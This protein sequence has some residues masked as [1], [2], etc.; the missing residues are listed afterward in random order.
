[1]DNQQRST[2]SI[3]ECS[4]TKQAVLSLDILKLLFYNLIN[5]SNNR[6][7]GL[8][9]GQKDLIAV[10]FA[11]GMTSPMMDLECVDPVIKRTMQK[12]TGNENREEKR[13]G[14]K[15]MEVLQ[16][17][18]RNYLSIEMESMLST[19]VPTR[20]NAL[21]VEAQKNSKF[22]IG[23]DM[24]RMFQKECAIMT[25]RTLFFYAPFVMEEFTVKL[26]GGPDNMKNALSVERLI[27]P[28]NLM[29]DVDDAKQESGI[30]SMERARF[31]RDSKDI[32]HPSMKVL[33]SGVDEVWATDLPNQLEREEIFRIHL[34]KRGRDPKKF[35]VLLL[36]QNTDNFTGAE[37]E[38]N[39]EDGM[40][41]SFDLDVEVDNS[42][43]LQAIKATVPQASRDVEE[44]SAV[45]EWVKTRA[46]LVS[47]ADEKE[48]SNKADN[49][50][51]QIVKKKGA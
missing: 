37:I 49:K 27:D 21:N 39:I 25:Q 40:F 38:S 13:N 9:C 12:E 24:V 3:G 10:L 47:G 30:G 16:N 34:Q 28:T 42:H 26:T 45:R 11:D 20:A 19:F 17:L 15:S 7:G 31:A 32:V 43:I 48:T 35:N 46:R 4:E 23:I 44:I 29:E 5:S 2:Q 33:D 22:I 8:R 36:A 50:V 41:S 14:M 18:K 1:M 6:T 51:R